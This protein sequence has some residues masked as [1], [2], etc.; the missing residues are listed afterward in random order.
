MIGTVSN[1]EQLLDVRDKLNQTIT[2]VN[3]MML[4][5]DGATSYVS[6]NCIYDSSTVGSD[7]PNSF[8]FPFSGVNVLNDAQNI[9]SSMIMPYDG[10][11]VSATIKTDQ[12]FP[13]NLLKFY[14]N[15][16]YTDSNIG[17]SLSAG[18]SIKSNFAGTT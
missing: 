2:Q 9:S 3:D 7:L 6:L 1:G 16:V 11:V 4:S 12:D 17:S 10:E 5:G 15:G 18:V 13:F 14:K 8:Y